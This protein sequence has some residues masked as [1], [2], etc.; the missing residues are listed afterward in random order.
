MNQQTLV[1]IVVV[2][3][4]AAAAIAIFLFARTNAVASGPYCG[5]NAQDPNLLA[6]QI[7][8]GT[9]RTCLRKGVGKGKRLP[10][11][12]KYAGGYLPIDSRK[13][14]CGDANVVPPG[15]DR[16]GNLAQ[17]LQKGIGVGKRQRVLQGRPPLL[18]FVRY[19]S[20]IALWLLLSSS[21]FIILILSRPDIIINTDKNN[22]KYID[23]NKLFFLFTP[24]C[25]LIGVVVFLVWKLYVLKKY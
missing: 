6:G 25:A 4:I 15:Y 21:L 3:I 2:T 11:D 7:Q 16:Q 24:M 17:C 8:L 14:Y 10:Y 18:T 22:K 1:I 12:S 5:N 13:I 9:L 23:W 20:P 19:I